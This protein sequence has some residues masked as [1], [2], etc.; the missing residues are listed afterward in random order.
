MVPS[1]RFELTPHR[2]RAEYATVK[3]QLGLLHIK[4][5]FNVPT[6]DHIRDLKLTL[7]FTRTFHV[8]TSFVFKFLLYNLLQ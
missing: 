6:L 7:S 5:V 2:L 1:V 8:I 4:F 3:R